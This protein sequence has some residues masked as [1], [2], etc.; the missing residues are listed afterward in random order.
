MNGGEFVRER[1]MAGECNVL[2]G[3]G[4][5]SVDVEVEGTVGVTDDGD[6]EHC[7][8]IVLLDLFGPL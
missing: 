8:P 7:N 1:L 3:V 6:I 5:L 4:G 2:V